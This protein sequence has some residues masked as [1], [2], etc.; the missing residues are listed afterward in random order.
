MMRKGRERAVRIADRR[1]VIRSGRVGRY[2]PRVPRVNMPME[3]QAIAVITGMAAQ[4]EEVKE[5]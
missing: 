4:S 1:G 5:G 2:S 3:G